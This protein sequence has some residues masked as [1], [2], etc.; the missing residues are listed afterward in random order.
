[1]SLCATVLGVPNNR[2]HRACLLL[3][4]SVVWLAPFKI[5]MK[6]LVRHRQEDNDGDYLAK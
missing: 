1:M 6:E 4:D 3:A 2:M 5:L